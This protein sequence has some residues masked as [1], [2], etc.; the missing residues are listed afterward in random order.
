ML[1]RHIDA[2][3]SMLRDI[4]ANN[5]KIISHKN[6]ARLATTG[7]V[8]AY[9]FT[10]DSKSKTT[11]T[12]G[13]VASVG[14]L[15]YRS[16]EINKAKQVEVQ[17]LEILKKATHKI[18]SYGYEDYKIER[19]VNH[20]NEYLTK[21][22]HISHHLDMAI[23]KENKRILR[24]STLLE[25][26]RIRLM[27]LTSEI[28]YDLKLQ[29]LE[30][31]REIDPSIKGD[32]IVTNYNSNIGK[33]NINEVKK[34]SIMML[35]SITAILMIGV[36]FVFNEAYAGWGLIILIISFILYIVHTFF[37]WLSETRK[38]RDS[39]I[40]FIGEFENVQSIKTIKYS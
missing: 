11:K 6:T 13:Q 40:K 5:Q 28:P 18:T 9:L 33:I 39:I 14:G 26:N 12:L 22:L 23:N 38:L 31:L 20:K 17:N 15:L 27:N 25:K 32:N 29:L 30:N 7:A 2:L 34:E 37:P 10:N 35:A 21:V 4:E 16:S 24:L 3:D 8:I 19:N 36:V 1:I